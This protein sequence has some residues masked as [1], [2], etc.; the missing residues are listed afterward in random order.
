M[1]E[2]PMFPMISGSLS[3][4]PLHGA[5]NIEELI[6]KIAS[7]AEL[8]IAEDGTI[9][10]VTFLINEQNLCS[11][12]YNFELDIPTMLEYNLA[13]AAVLQRYPSQFYGRVISLNLILNNKE[14]Q[15]AICIGA[16]DLRSGEFCHRTIMVMRNEE[17]NSVRSLFRN[18]NNPWSPEKDGIDFLLGRCIVTG[19]IYE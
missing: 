2:Q 19:D 10:T 18:D 3:E 9:G 4:S 12:M 14:T 1:T 11:V 7:Q 6:S 8:L 15:E 13:V 17:D 16:G 5:S